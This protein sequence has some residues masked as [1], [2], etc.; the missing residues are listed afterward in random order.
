[1]AKLTNSHLNPPQGYLPSFAG[2]QAREIRE[3]SNITWEGKEVHAGQTES[4]LELSVE[5]FCTAPQDLAF[6]LLTQRILVF[7]F[8]K[9]CLNFSRQDTFFEGED[10]VI[11]VFDFDYALMESFAVKVGWALM[12]FP[13]FLVF[14][15]LA[16]VPCFLK[17]AV[18]W[19]VYCQHV[20][21]T[22]GKE[23]GHSKP[24]GSTDIFCS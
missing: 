5:R 20:C 17:K 8:C 6:R 1:M 2:V 10:D 13:P 19:D 24:F 11:A 3:G 21:V 4:S 18:Q 22:R 23:Q 12:A 7:H 16:L 14:G 9:T 15:C